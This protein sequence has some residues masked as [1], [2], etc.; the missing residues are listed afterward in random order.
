MAMLY[1][2]PST[3]SDG[4][5]TRCGHLRR[6]WLSVSSPLRVTIGPSLAARHRTLPPLSGGPPKGSEADD[7]LLGPLR[8]LEENGLVKLF[9]GERKR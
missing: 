3:A 1:L 4:K 9:S 8:S 5:A 2:L 6:I 7:V